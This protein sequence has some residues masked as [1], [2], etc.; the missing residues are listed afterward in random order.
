MAPFAA[1]A[2]SDSSIARIGR[3]GRNDLGHACSKLPVSRRMNRAPPHIIGRCEM[4]RS[5][6]CASS[7]RRLLMLHRQQVHAQKMLRRRR[8]SFAFKIGTSTDA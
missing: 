8:L 5:S 3:S 6:C 2:G 4:A 7:S 1:L